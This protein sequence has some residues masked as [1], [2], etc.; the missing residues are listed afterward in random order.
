MLTRWKYR[1]IVWFFDKPDALSRRV[2]VESKLL[3]H[4]KA[5]TRPTPQECMKLA[6]KLGVPT[7]AQK[8]PNAAVKPRSEAESA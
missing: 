2:E 7:W 5:G 3:S 1:F 4:F 8:R 6:M